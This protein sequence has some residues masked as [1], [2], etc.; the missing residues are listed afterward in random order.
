MFVTVNSVYTSIFCMSSKFFITFVLE[1]FFSLND[2]SKEEQYMKGYN[3]Y[4]T[5]SKVNIKEATL[6]Q[7]CNP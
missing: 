2:E 7:P 1:F 5:F 6:F 3:Q 4:L